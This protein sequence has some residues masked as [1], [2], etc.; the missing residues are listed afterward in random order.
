MSA[1][2][3]RTSCVAAAAGRRVHSRRARRKHTDSDSG[4]SGGDACTVVPVDAHWARE[5]GAC[6]HLSP[7]LVHQGRKVLQSQHCNVAMN[8]RT[9][10]KPPTSNVPTSTTDRKPLSAIQ[11][12]LPSYYAD[13]EIRRTLPLVSSALGSMLRSCMPACAGPRSNRP[14]CRARRCFS[15]L[16]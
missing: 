13:R 12:R 4:G 7:R 10:D 16:L 9:S 3:G 15:R 11:T 8:V 2:A 1:S 5:A 14:H 6:V